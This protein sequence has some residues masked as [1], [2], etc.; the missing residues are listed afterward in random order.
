MEEPSVGFFGCARTDH[1]AQ[2]WDI[3]AG[4]LFREFRRIHWA[5]PYVRESNTPFEKLFGPFFSVIYE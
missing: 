4:V 3:Y 5:R 1:K 2:I